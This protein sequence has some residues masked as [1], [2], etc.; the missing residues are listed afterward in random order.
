MSVDPETALAAAHAALD[1]AAARTAAAYD[2]WWAASTDAQ[3]RKRQAEWERAREAQN[4]AAERLHRANAALGR[5]AR[6][7]RR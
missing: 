4:K 6:D 2:A 5:P 1:A 7:D 3:E